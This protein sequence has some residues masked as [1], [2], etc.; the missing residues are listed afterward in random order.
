LRLAARI[1]SLVE[2]SD[3]L[4]RLRDE[5][6]RQQ[7][8]RLH[9]R[10]GDRPGEILRRAVAVTDGIFTKPP[11]E[12]TRRFFCAPIRRNV[13]IGDGSPARCV[14]QLRNCETVKCGK[15]ARLTLSDEIQEFLI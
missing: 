2:L 5:F 11:G 7:P 9:E 6:V 3:K 14:Y 8:D 12:P 13:Q 4:K 1:R 10:S 15:Y